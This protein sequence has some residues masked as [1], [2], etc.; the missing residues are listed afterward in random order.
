MI[1]KIGVKH[2]KGH[3]GKTLSKEHK[4][5]LSE[6]HKGKTLSKE[7]KKKLSEAGLRRSGKIL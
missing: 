5:K 4:K 1:F 7:H 6:A 3:K 2:I